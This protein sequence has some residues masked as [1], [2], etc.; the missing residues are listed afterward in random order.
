L[1]VWVDSFESL[2]RKQL[3]ALLPHIGDEQE[4]VSVTLFD[5]DLCECKRY[6]TLI[7]YENRPIADRQF[8]KNVQFYLHQCGNVTLGQFFIQWS[9]KGPLFV[10]NAGQGL[11]LAEVPPMP[12][13]V[14][15]FEKIT[16][17]FA[18]FFSNS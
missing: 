7:Q 8:V 17:K 2:S 9:S 16:I 5:I 14:K 3:A 1:E 13:N 4:E 18:L 15:S 11:P 12:S 10:N 6:L